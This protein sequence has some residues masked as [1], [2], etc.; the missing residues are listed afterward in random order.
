[1]VEDVIE[2]GG[3]DEVVRFKLRAQVVRN[4]SGYIDPVLIDALML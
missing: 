2:V 1:M 4:H 3:V